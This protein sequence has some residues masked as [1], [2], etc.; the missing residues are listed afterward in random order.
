MYRAFSMAVL[1]T[2]GLAGGSLAA[3]ASLDRQT[4]MKNVGAATGV[5]AKLAKGEMEFD[6]ATAQLVFNTL[7]AAANGYGYMFGEGTESG[8]DTEASPKIWE[9]RAGFDAA[10]AQFAADTNVKITDL[11]SFQAA[12]GAATKNCGTC[13]ETYR[14]KKQ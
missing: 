1:L 4:V 3:D 14:I 10:V 13:H 2:V 8:N 11:A 12:F 6:P 7:N 9:D 5:G